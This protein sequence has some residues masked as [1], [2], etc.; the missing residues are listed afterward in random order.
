M[1]KAIPLLA[2]APDWIT[3]PPAPEGALGWTVYDATDDSDNPE[4]MFQVFL[5]Q[6][7]SDQ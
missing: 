2:E 3:L 7:G 1:R 4:P 6:P 5:L